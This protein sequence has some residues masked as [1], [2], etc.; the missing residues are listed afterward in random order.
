MRARARWSRAGGVRT[1]NRRADARSAEGVRFGG[2]SR[3]EACRETLQPRDLAGGGRRTDPR[4][5]RQEVPPPARRHRSGRSRAAPPRAVRGRA[6]RNRRSHPAQPRVR[7]R[8]RPPDGSPSR[9]PLAGCTWHCTGAPPQERLSAP[10]PST[11]QLRH[12]SRPLRSKGCTDGGARWGWRTARAHRW[13]AWDFAAVW[14]I[15]RNPWCGHASGS[16]ARITR[17][18]LPPTIRAIWS[19]VKPR[20][21][22]RPM[23]VSQ[24]CAM[25]WV[26]TS[27]ER[28]PGSSG[29]PGS[30]P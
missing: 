26:S 16:T 30:Q 28:R 9:R 29:L 23:N 24:C 25:V 20:S 6:R 18:K 4:P 27:L 12:G 7:L 19:S 11:E 3:A 1:A 22:S 15:V 8:R 13:T 2:S 17:R 14:R 10:R 5:E 21:A